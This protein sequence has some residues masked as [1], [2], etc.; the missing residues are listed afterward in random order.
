[1]RKCW[2]YFLKGS[3][4]LKRAAWVILD[5]ILHSTRPLSA[6]TC[7]NFFT[8]VRPFWKTLYMRQTYRIIERAE[9]ISSCLFRNPMK[10]FLIFLDCAVCEFTRK[11][12]F[13]TYYTYLITL[14]RSGIISFQ[15]CFFFLFFFL[16]THANL[17]AHI[18]A[19]LFPGLPLFL[20]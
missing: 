11:N 12:L 17:C 5:I 20:A 8:A 19:S 6:K 4:M 2:I 1:M 16:C 18:L 7:I 14:A 9:W 15:L 3:L 13:S 10:V